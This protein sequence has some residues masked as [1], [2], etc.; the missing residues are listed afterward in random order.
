MIRSLRIIRLAACR[1]YSSTSVSLRRGKFGLPGA[2]DLGTSLSIDDNDREKK[3]VATSA[4][5]NVYNDAFG[6]KVKWKKFA[7]DITMR[8]HA[9]R[10]KRIVEREQHRKQHRST[11]DLHLAARAKVVSEYQ[12]TGESSLSYREIQRLTKIN[13]LGKA[14][15]KRDVLELRLMEFFRRMDPT[16]VKKMRWT[17]IINIR[18]NLDG[19]KDPPEYDKEVNKKYEI[20][21]QKRSALELGRIVVDLK[22]YDE[23]CRIE[24]QKTHDK[25]RHEEVSGAFFASP[26]KTGRSSCR[27]CGEAIAKDTI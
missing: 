9:V 4:E 12:Q 22:H 3:I 10:A 21:A 26:A 18:F 23:C 6:G 20:E 8:Q 14:T 13:N 16:R 27:I 25:S 19:S 5:D 1:A 2:V 17:E 15:G 7:E 24:S 11:Q